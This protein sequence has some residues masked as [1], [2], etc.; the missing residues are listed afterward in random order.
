MVKQVK[1]VARRVAV[2]AVAQCLFAVERRQWRTGANQTDQ[3]E[4]HARA[5]LPVLFK[6][7][8]AIN[9]AARE[10]EARVGLKLDLIIQIV[11]AQVRVCIA[12][13]VDYQQHCLKQR[14]FAYYPG[15]PA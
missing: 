13:P 4:S 7:L 6:K 11:F 15:Q 12:Q 14:V 1:E 10:S 5:H 2:F 9:I 8:H 3:V